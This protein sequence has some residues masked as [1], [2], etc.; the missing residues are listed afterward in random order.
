MCWG[1]NRKYGK[2]FP[3]ITKL[4]T[5]YSLKAVHMAVLKDL[6][7]RPFSELKGMVEFA[8]ISDIYTVDGKLRCLYV[9]NSEAKWM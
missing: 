9:A 7:G 6:F 4:A 2:N 5:L 3:A 8:P 1:Y